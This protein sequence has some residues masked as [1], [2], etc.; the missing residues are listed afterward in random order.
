MP[1]KKRSP[2]GSR[3]VWYKRAKHNI[4]GKDLQSLMTA[5]LSQL[6]DPHSRF[7][8]PPA[9][10]SGLPQPDRLGINSF[11]DYKGFLVGQFLSFEPGQKQPII[12]VKNKVKA[13]SLDSISAG[14]AGEEFL[15]GVCHFAIF[16][17]H[18]LIAQTRALGTREFEPYIA[19]LL[20]TATTVTNN[21][22]AIIIADQPTNETI[23]RAAN[24][25]IKA[26]TF[27]TPIRPVSG[28]ETVE[29]KNVVV[30]EASGGAFDALR[31]LL[32]SDIFDKVKLT[33]ALADTEIEV[34]VTVRVKGRR[35]ISDDAHQFLGSIAQ[36]ARH[37]HQDDIA[38]EVQGVGK[39]VGK[40]LRINKNIS[41]RLLESGG[42][43]DE[44]ALWDKMITWFTSMVSNKTISG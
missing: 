42:L 24:K 37:M 16:K 36:S 12:R 7:W 26:V 22:A 29:G 5:A 15:E 34:Q 44:S 43:V 13:F 8:S 18:V 38:V 32:G 2:T 19:W 4:E 40:D 23:R 17:D 14:A 35:S 31:D 20:G 28:T 10:Q 41:V 33:D 1:N 25:K 39:L 3:S 21:S 9:V 27:G 30:Y 6:P 11:Y